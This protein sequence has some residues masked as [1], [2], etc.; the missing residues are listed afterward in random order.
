MNR[1]SRVLVSLTY[2]LIVLAIICTPVVGRAATVAT[3]AFSVAAGSYTGTQSVT[4]S[5]ATSGATIY[6]TTNGTTPSITSTK[7]TG[8]I[9]VST[10]ETIKAIA[11]LTG[12]TNSAV[13]SA[14]YTITV[15]TPAFTPATGTYH[16]AQSVTLSDATSGATIYYTTNGKTPSSASTKYTGT[17]TVS[18]SETI[19][20]IAELTGDT[21]SAVSTAT[22]TFQAPTPTFSLPTGS[23]A[24]SLSVTISDANSTATIYYTTNGKTPTTASTIYTA[25]TAITVNATETLEAIA[26]V[27]GYANS[28]PA[29]ATYTIST[30]PGTLTVY[31]SQPGAQSTTVVGAATETFDALSTAN[32]HTSPYLST[33]GIGTYGGSATNPFAILSHDMYGGAIDS[34][35]NGAATNYYAVGKASNSTNAAYLTFTQPVSYFGFWWSAGDAYNRVAIYSGNTLCGSF[36]TADLL[37]FLKNGTGTITALNGSTYKT[38]AYFGNPNLASGSNDSTEPFAYVSFSITGVMITQ[39]AF[40]NTSTSSSFKSDN[41]SAIF[42][43]NTVTIPTTFAKVETLTLGSQVA[44]PIFTP[45]GGIPLNLEISSTTPG[46]SI[47][48][49]KDG[50]TPTT[51]GTACNTPT[52][53]CTIQVTAAETIKAI[54]YETGMTNSPVTSVTYT[55]PTLSV[56]SSSNPSIY[57][58]PV[59]FTATISSGP[60]GTVT[61]YDSGSSIGTGTISG[62]KATLTISTL[63]IGA[64]TITAGWVGNASYGSVLSSAITQTVSKEAQT[65]NFP[66]PGAQ[67]IGT[68]LALSATASS[69]LPVTFGSQT[70]SV[71]TVSESSSGVWTLFLLTSGDCSLV[72]TQAGNNVYALADALQTF[73]VYKASQSITFPAISAQPANTT[74]TLNGSASSGLAITY[75]ATTPAV[76]AISSTG[77]SA[78]LAAEGTCTIQANQSGNTTYA[79]AA[80]VTKSFTVTAAAPLLQLRMAPTPAAVTLSSAANLDWVL[81]QVAGSSPTATRKANASLISDL[82]VQAG[83]YVYSDNTVLFNWT[84]GSPTATGAAVPAGIFFSPSIQIT[85]PADTTVKT[86]NLYVY[87]Q[88]GGAQL[89]ASLSDGSS[90]VLTHLAATAQDGGYEIYSIDYSAAS[91]GQALTVQLAS[92]NGYS[93]GVQAAVLQPH[94]PQVS[95]SAPA[96]EFVASGGSTASI[97]VTIGVTQYDT[98]ISSVQLEVNG[99]QAAS[100]TTAPYQT[101]LTESPGHY[102]LQAQAT[103]TAGLSNTSA[104]QALDVIGTGGTLSESFAQVTSSV[105]LTSLGTADWTVFTSTS[106]TLGQGVTHK[107][108]V[109]PLIST[110]NSCSDGS[111]YWVDPGGPFSFD[112]GTPDARETGLYTSTTFCAVDVVVRWS[113]LFGQVFRVFKWNNCSS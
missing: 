4:L 20:A 19:Q 82:T 24:G 98:P 78:V 108:N 43:G 14:A 58:T 57:G 37:S 76:C 18:T 88:E 42:S 86:L 53:P 10:S 65:I 95:I 105:D 89:T 64:H 111:G 93:I 85:A 25:G 72:A 75:T 38:S 35:S 112:D 73:W 67:T 46:A 96:E 87:V 113:R 81:W 17:I 32:P 69:G 91:S 107:A 52:T 92:L 48:Y 59:T 30:T 62:A 6:Y 71:C 80:T 45:E 29:S 56:A 66:N 28:A 31:L 1:I 97:P 55:M 44:A 61:F 50:S 68:P 49:T 102:I 23:Y 13:A 60:T 94:L 77:S 100:L 12:D 70:T 22:Y 110:A 109:I 54:A 39:V 101:S 90:P 63:A 5:D 99:T 3:P 74:L 47:S 84:G 79:A 36:S 41:H 51:T 7:Y 106:P 26:V 21:N 103:D 2:A 11:E 27:T 104:T 33:A 16:S 40:Y 8:S 83:G 34:S 9:A 15:P